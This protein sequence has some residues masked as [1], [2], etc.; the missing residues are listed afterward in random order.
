[1]TPT[2]GPETINKRPK[3]SQNIHVKF[4]R[5]YPSEAIAE[6]DTIK[7]LEAPFLVKKIKTKETTKT[8]QFKEEINNKHTPG[9]DL[10][11][12]K[13]LQELSLIISQGQ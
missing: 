2:N 3:Y 4:S 8:K 5:Q 10:I 11:P 9:I 7:H 1:M 6:E 12:G 13:V